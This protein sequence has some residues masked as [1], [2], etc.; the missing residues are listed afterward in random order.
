MLDRTCCH[1]GR[2]VADRHGPGDH[3]SSQGGGALDAAGG[4]LQA[5]D[6][7][8]GLRQQGARGLAEGQQREAGGL[9]VRAVDVL[10][11]M[12]GSSVIVK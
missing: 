5:Q 11:I 10:C 4:H 9:S 12:K 1:C 6:R 2:S 8:V 7:R 3:A